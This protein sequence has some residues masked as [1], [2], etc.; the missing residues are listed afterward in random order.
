MSLLRQGKAQ[1]LS[2]YLGESDVWRGE[3]LYVAIVQYLRQQGCAGATV[4]RAVAGYGAG[5][6]LHSEKEW[7]LFSDAP[8][9]VQVI[10]Q[11]E[12]L[13]RLLPHLQEMLTGGLITLQ[14]VEVLKYTHAQLHGLPTHLSV[15]QV[16]EPVVTTVRPITPLAEVVDLLLNAPF[17]VLPVV[18]GA[19]LLQGIISI[20]DLITAGILPMRR[21]LIHT[22][23]TLDEQSIQTIEAPLEQ[24]RRQILTA[25]EVM[26]RQVCTIGPEMSVREAA[27]MMIETGLRSLP[28]V[29]PTGN[30]LGMLTRT[31]LLQM[32]VTSPL[33]QSQMQS[34][35]TT[36]TQPLDRRSS[37]LERPPQERPIGDYVSTEIATVEQSAPLADVI[38]ALTASSFKRVIVTDDEEHV[39]GII[40]DVDILSHVQAVQRPGLMRW[41]TGWARGVPGRLPTAALRPPHGNGSIAS[42][43]MHRDV[44]TVTEDTSVQQTVE[45]MLRSHRK[46]LPVVDAEQRLVGIIGR[47]EVLGILLEG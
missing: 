2:I 44:V 4:T 25:Q 17:Q 46:A 41:L 16:M 37:H 40:S 22:A 8:V 30:V 27:Q 19:N 29:S 11:P 20:G 43:L 12:R 47:S 6:R 18:D 24:A 3:T 15:R 26:N 13:H 32:V 28:V 33:M 5:G 23:L 21:G 7:R 45:T 31:D 38:E 36:K 9:I 42:D 1:M 39:V 14:D 35:T 34:Q 10:D